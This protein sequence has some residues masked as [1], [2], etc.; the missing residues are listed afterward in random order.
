MVAPGVDEESLV[1]QLQMELQPLLWKELLWKKDPPHIPIPKHLHC[2]F[3]QR[4]PQNWP[5]DAQTQME[6]FDGPT[7]G[8]RVQA[9]YTTV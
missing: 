5:I 7:K 3:H 1:V 6:G 2:C 8:S 4:C 9:K